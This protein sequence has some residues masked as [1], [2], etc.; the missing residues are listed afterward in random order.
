MDREHFMS[1][2][3]SFNA[4]DFQALRRYWSDA[5]ELELPPDREGNR[6]ILCGPDAIIA[7]YTRL[8]DYVREH[9]E[10]DYLAIDEDRIA[11]EIGTTFEAIQDHPDF[12][13]QPLRRGDVFVMNNFVHF[14]LQAGLL[15]RIRVARY[16][17]DASRVRGGN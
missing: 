15:H 14:N 3:A 12:A 9:L 7:S 2:V 5:V 1:Y 6:R 11:C 16:T 10:I 4:R 17:Q 8:F 13:A